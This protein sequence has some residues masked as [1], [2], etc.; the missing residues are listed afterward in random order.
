MLPVLTIVDD[1]LGADRCAELREEVIADGFMTVKIKEG[2][3]LP[4]AIYENVNVTIKPSEINEKLMEVFG[5]PVEMLNQ[6]F[7]RGQ[8]GS[9]LHN[10]VHSDHCC[11]Q[12]AG[13]YYLNLP[14]QCLGGTAFWRH[15]KFGWDMMPTQEQLDEVGYN[16]DQMA[17]DW[18]D[19]DAWSMVSLA[20][21][22]MDR[23]ITYPTNA[24]HSRWP[25]NGF[26]H[27]NESARLIYCCFFDLL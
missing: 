18:Q 10:L 21:M 5:R 9:Q 6:A 23:L 1:F 13:V 27:T 19:P 4:E 7:R 22:K 2:K 12:L 11:A 25:W 14:H 8:Q 20:G 16:I 24:F 3:D 17:A 26:G 15:R